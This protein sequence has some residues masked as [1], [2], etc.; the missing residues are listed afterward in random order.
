MPVLVP[1]AEEGPGVETS[2]LRLGADDY[3]LKPFDPGVLLSRVQ[4]A[5]RRAAAV[6]A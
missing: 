2:V 6:A 3:I 4:A 5:F 1:T